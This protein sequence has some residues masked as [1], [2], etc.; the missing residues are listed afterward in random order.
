MEAQYQTTNTN[1]L[2]DDRS[3][4]SLSTD[5]YRYEKVLVLGCVWLFETPWTVARQVPLSTEFTR[6]EYWNG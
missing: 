5:R 1:H 3:T 4:Q 6:K 2:G